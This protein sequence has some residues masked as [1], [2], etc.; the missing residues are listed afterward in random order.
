M[1]SSTDS[2]PMLMRTRSSGNSLAV[3]TSEG[4]DAWD[5]IPG[6]EM[7]DVTE[8]NDTVILNRFVAV[9]MCLESSVLPVVKHTTEPPPDA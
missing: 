6:K 2:M 3:F 9:T 8:P 7:S 5:M 4:M 1:R